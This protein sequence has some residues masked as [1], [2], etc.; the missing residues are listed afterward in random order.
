[1]DDYLGIY[2]G[3]NVIPAQNTSSLGNLMLGNQGLRVS[4]IRI[5]AP[6]AVKVVRPVTYQQSLTQKKA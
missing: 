5:L 4:G 1:M 6:F 2:L 3:R